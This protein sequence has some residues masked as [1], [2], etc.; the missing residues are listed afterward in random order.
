MQHQSRHTRHS[1]RRINQ[2]AS[3]AQKLQ[4]VRNADR[5]LN[6]PT[7]FWADH[8]LSLIRLLVLRQKLSHQFLQDVIEGYHAAG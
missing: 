6:Q 3:L 7:S 4:Q 1:P 5:P 8:D 2:Q